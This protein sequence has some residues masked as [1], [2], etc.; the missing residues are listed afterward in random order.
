M[1]F[2]RLLKLC[3]S[4]DVLVNGPKLVTKKN[5]Y[6]GLCKIEYYIY[7]YIYIHI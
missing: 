7:M 3:S 1:C 4:D 6:I 2:P 5:T